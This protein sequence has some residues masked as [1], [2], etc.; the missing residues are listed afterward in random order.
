MRRLLITGVAAGLLAA[1][2][3]PSS[4]ERKAEW[5]RVALEGPPSRRLDK[6]T[7]WLKTSD[8]PAAAQLVTDLVTGKN[9]DSTVARAR[10]A[11][12][13]GERGEGLS[14]LVRLLDS[15]KGE[16]QLAAIEG[17]GATGDP[18]VIQYLEPL[19][20]GADSSVSDAASSAIEHVKDGVVTRVLQLDDYSQAAI[21]EKES[22]TAEQWVF[23]IRSVAPYVDGDD[24]ADLA[25]LYDEVIPASVR[26]ELVMT[27]SRVPGE[28]AG[29]FVR[30]KLNASEGLVRA[31]AIN[32][33]VRRGDESSLARLDE[34]AAGDSDWTLRRA[35]LEAARRLRFDS[36]SG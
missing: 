9:T 5:A 26:A 25:K 16:L 8:E 1:A 14:L 36:E 35:A 11:K 10:A 18:K 3:V 21:H 30:D 4:P 33:V 12:I 6:A 27:I 19:S 31:A 7:A 13:L 24:V 17:L 2:C 20:K 32:A 34:I 22:M 29:A 23:A 15:D 28:E